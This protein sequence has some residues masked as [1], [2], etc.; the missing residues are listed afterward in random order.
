MEVLFAIKDPDL[1]GEE[2][3]GKNCLS[4]KS[5]QAK[6]GMLQSVCK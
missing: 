4:L 5:A 2:F 1:G 6:G 3:T